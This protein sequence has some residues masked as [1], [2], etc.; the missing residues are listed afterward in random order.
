MKRSSVE[1]LQ[2]TE[3]SENTPDNL[4]NFVSLYPIGVVFDFSWSPQCAL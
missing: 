1:V 2:I 3:I 4:N